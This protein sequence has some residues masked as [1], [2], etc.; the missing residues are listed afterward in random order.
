M[1]ISNNSI[2]RNSLFLYLRMIVVM[3]VSLYTTRIVLQTLGVDDYGIFN[4][5]ASLVVM[6]NFINTALVSSTQR[7]LNFEL[8]RGIITRV[9]EVFCI[10]LTIFLLSVPV[11]ILA[12][13]TVGIWFLNQ[14]AN[15]PADRLVAA[16]WVFQFTLLGYCFKTVQIPYNALII[17]H[18]QMSFYSLSCILESILLLGGVLLLFCFPKDRLIFYA[19]WNSTAAMLILLFYYRYCKKHFPEAQF[20]FRLNSKYSREIFIFSGWSLLGTLAN[21]TK[22]QGILVI[23]NIFCGVAASG[24]L[25]LANQ[26]SNA[27]YT[28]VSSF[29]VAFNPQLVKSYAAGDYKYFTDLV[30]HTSKYSFLLLWFLLLPFWMITPFALEVWLGNVPEHVV[31]FTRLTTLALL[32]DTLSAPLWMA[33]QTIGNI[34]NY[35]LIISFLILL[36]ILFSYIGL[37]AGYPPAVALVICCLINVI[38]HAARIVYLRIKVRFPVL[39]Y[40]RRTMLPV[41]IVLLVTLAGSWGWHTILRSFQ[42]VS[43]LYE[44][45]LIGGCGMFNMVGIVLLGLNKEERKNIY[46]AASRLMRQLKMKLL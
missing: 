40:L 8:G 5:A 23:I 22:Q 34:R 2:V 36:S 12:G 14:Q 30:F 44:L 32:I 16:N 21:V 27:V 29:Q 43:L 6:F 15:I 18:E 9:A 19:F 37:K 39:S 45:L 38:C 28:F 11:V 35:Q 25:A 26:V 10:C 41:T 3:G 13:E 31:T 17:A 24:A 46:A 42:S 4:V 7:F 1:I 33:V 20:H